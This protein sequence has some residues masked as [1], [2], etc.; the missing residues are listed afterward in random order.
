MLLIKKKINRNNLNDRDIFIHFITLQD[1]TIMHFN[2]M[3]KYYSAESGFVFTYTHNQFSIRYN[4][5][6]DNKIYLYVNETKY[7]VKY[8]YHK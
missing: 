2:C 5:C 7:N 8:I 4:C 6:S 3:F 1:G